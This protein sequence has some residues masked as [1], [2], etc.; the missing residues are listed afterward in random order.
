M[1]FDK[2]S[3]KH[4][5]KQSI[6]TF[7]RKIGLEVHYWRPETER[8]TLEGTFHRLLEH[9]IDFQ[10]VIDVGASN[11]CWSLDLQRF[12]PG[13]A[14]LLIEANPIREPALATLC[15]NN[16]NWHYVLKAAGEQEGVLF[17]DDPNPQGGHLSEKQLSKNYKPF[18]VTTIDAEVDRLGLTPPFLI[19][20]DTHGVEVPILGGSSKTLDLCDVLII[21]CYN[22]PTDPPCLSFWEMCSWM[23]DRGFLPLDVHDVLYRQHDHAFWQ[24]DIV[25]ARKTRA[26]F[27]YRA[28]K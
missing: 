22:F 18:P 6:K 20:L 21:E 23:A 5:A 19:K 2:E 7:F 15:R 14:H 26:E 1:K 16:P 3:C 24:L 25:F 17:F 9:R 12:F 11:G 10:T 28:Y 27:A 13:K 4:L 8:P